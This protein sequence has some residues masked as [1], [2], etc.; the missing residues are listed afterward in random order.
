MILCN[1]PLLP[2]SGW[3]QIVCVCKQ[4]IT[5]QECLFYFQRF[6][7]KFKTINSRRY[8][9]G[10]CCQPVGN[11]HLCFF[12]LCKRPLVRCCCFVKIS[13]YVVLLIRL[14]SRFCS[15]KAMPMLFPPFRFV[16]SDIVMPKLN[17]LPLCMPRKDDIKFSRFTLLFSY[18]FTSSERYFFFHFLGLSNFV[19]GKF[20]ISISLPKCFRLWVSN[21]LCFFSFF[22]SYLFDERLYFDDHLFLHSAKWVSF[23][24]F[25]PQEPR[26]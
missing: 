7:N 8:C 2:I 22:F 16:S 24:F 4:Q 5:N 6:Q 21:R 18:C 19:F 1:V 9:D 20:W 26:S 17:F 10:Q 12:L 11:K 25:L 3:F 15:P 13:Q 23:R 14:L